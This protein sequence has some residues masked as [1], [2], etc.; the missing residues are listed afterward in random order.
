MR[1]EGKLGEVAQGEVVG[2]RLVVR[3]PAPVDLQAA[4][5]VVRSRACAFVRETRF[6]RAWH[7]SRRATLRTFISL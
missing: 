2:A 5:R 4:R 7:G 6:E 1:P 3:E